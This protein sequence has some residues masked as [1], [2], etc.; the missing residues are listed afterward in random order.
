MIWFSIKYFSF[1]FISFHNI[2]PICI[3]IP[4]KSTITT[5][6]TTTTI[7][8]L[9]GFCP[10]LPGS[11]S[12][13]KVKTKPIY[14]LKQ[15][16]SEWQWDQLGHIICTLP[17]TANHASTPPFSFFTGQMSFSPPNQQRQ[18]TEGKFPKSFNSQMPQVLHE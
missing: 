15:E 2:L 17:Q 18:S 16:T 6:T 11:A 1:H 13:R 7:L 9:S 8:R 4:Q 12:N 3:Q 5:T 10:G 14:F